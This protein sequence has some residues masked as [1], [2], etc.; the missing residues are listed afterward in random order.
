MNNKVYL[1]TKV[2]PFIANQKKGKN[3][4]IDSLQRE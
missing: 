1:A 2:L 3:G 4:E